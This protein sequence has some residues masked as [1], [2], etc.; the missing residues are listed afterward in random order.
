M[1][2]NSDKYCINVLHYSLTAPARRQVPYQV[3]RQVRRVSNLF[4]AKNAPLTPKPKACSNTNDTKAIKLYSKQPT[5]SAV[6][7]EQNSF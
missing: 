6:S 5:N 4:I 7:S 1:N 3:L 2:D